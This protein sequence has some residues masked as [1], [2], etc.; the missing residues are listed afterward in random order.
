MPIVGTAGHVD[1]GKSTLV[2][3]L[4]GT[5]PDR[6]AE[7]KRRGLTIDLGFAWAQ[8]DGIDVGFVDVPGHEKFIKNMLAGVGAIDCALMVIAADSGW[9]PQTEEHAAVLDLLDVRTGVIALTRIDLVDS[10]TVELAALE[11]MEETE[12]TALEGWPI[13]PVSPVSGEGLDALLGHLQAA[14][15]G[16]EEKP[17]GPLKMWVDRSFTISGAGVVATGTLARGEVSVGDELE[18]LP[19]GLRD[20]VRG[21]HH[22]DRPA[23]S[24]YSGSRTAVNL[25]N[26]RLSSI[27]RGDLVCAPNSISVSSR[28]IV[29]LRHARSFEEI[30]GRGAFHFHVGTAHT[31]ATIRQL[32]RTDN[33]LIDLDNPLPLAMGDRFILR[34][35]GRQAIVGGGRVLE[36][37][38]IDHPTMNQLSSLAESVDSSAD[39]RATALLT[40]RGS[41]QLDELA[42][43]SGGGEPLSGLRAGST[44]ISDAVAQQ[45]RSRAIEVVSEYHA[46]YPLRPGISKAELASTVD[47]SLGV[48]DAVIATDDALVETEGSVQA[49][50]FSNELPREMAERWSRAKADLETSFDVPRMSAI[51]LD[52]ETVHALIRSGELVQVGPDLAFTVDQIEEVQR[53]LADLAD[54]FSVSQFKDSFGMTRRQA[55]PI[56]EWLDS[57][58][59]TKRTGDGRTVRRRP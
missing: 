1:H 23:D 54:G 45:I 40:A 56:L 16:A 42:K 33:Y 47:V 38:A 7:E 31:P 20:T 35:S 32:H 18:I 14:I 58:G 53:R 10:D 6:W 57:L 55:V 44:V 22:H 4:T 50:G 12:D 34:D 36:P 41:A 25:Q 46:G 13:I 17:G 26:T 59:W 2:Q 19:S 39:E 3:A 24:S 27:G 15:A 37:N 5:D 11:I 43:A 52:D 48:I 8:I 51:D 49:V 28:L 30:P 21:L 9:M 29:Q